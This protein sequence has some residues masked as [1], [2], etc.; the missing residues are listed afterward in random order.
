MQ[1]PRGVALQGT[2]PPEALALVA[3]YVIFVYARTGMSKEGN[4]SCGRRRGAWVFV[5]VWLGLVGLAG[6]E[7]GPDLPPLLFESEHF[8]YHSESTQYDPSEIQAALESHYASAARAFGGRV[9]LPKKIR[10]NHFVQWDEQLASELCLLRTAAGCANLVS[11][12]V[13]SGRVIH[14]HELIHAYLVGLGVPHRIVSEGVAQALSSCGNLE[15]PTALASASS[16]DVFF[17]RDVAVGVYYRATEALIRYVIAQKGLDA[18]LR[19]FTSIRYDAAGHAFE[20]QFAR[21]FGEPLADAWERAK[22]RREN[23]RQPEPCL[24][25]RPLGEVSH[26][27]RKN[28]IVAGLSY[29]GV[30][31]LCLDVQETSGSVFG[32]AAFIHGLAQVTRDTWGESG[33]TKYT[34]AVEDRKWSILSGV[35]APATYTFPQIQALNYRLS[36]NPGQAVELDVPEGVYVGEVNV[37]KVDEPWRFPTRL[38]F[39]S[40]QEVDEVLFGQGSICRLDDAGGELECR[41]A[42]EWLGS[43]LSGRIE[44]RPEASGIRLN[45][46]AG[47]CFATL[48]DTKGRCVQGGPG[49][50]P[51]CAYHGFDLGYP[52]TESAQRA[53]LPVP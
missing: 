47:D 26:T 36:P 24:C 49:C 35:V 13:Y 32:L 44:I 22:A 39:H 30:A 52:N 50:P 27:D 8:V 1:R 19:N 7:G 31:P 46:N 28:L 18:V 34:Y 40:P 43:R 21:A 6:C 16:T 12:G 53:G 38:V 45:F 29:R 37:E 3:L 10:Y 11:G 41:R 17:Q 20:E 51:F 48:S 5:F 9:V 25:Y 33:A 2:S 4:G 23:V 15:A 42:E 14:E